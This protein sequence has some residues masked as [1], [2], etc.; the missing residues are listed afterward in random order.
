VPAF[1]SYLFALA[2]PSAGVGAIT[3]YQ[4]SKRKKEKLRNAK[5]QEKAGQVKTAGDYEDNSP[6]AKAIIEHYHKNPAKFKKIYS[7]YARQDGGDEFIN[8][9]KRF[10]DKHG[11]AFDTTGTEYHPRPGNFPRSGYSRPSSYTSRSRPTSSGGGSGAPPPRSGRRNPFDDCEDFFRNSR[12]RAD[13][14]HREWA[15]MRREYAERSARTYA[16]EQAREAEARA[17][18]MANIE[19][20]EKYVRRGTMAGVA[21]LGTYGVLNATVPEKKKRS[22]KSLREA[23]ILGASGGAA[24]LGAS[25]FKKPAWGAAGAL[26][27]LAVG[28]VNAWRREMRSKARKKKD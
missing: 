17:R 10:A 23:L 1:A 9:L 27:G 16:E 26:A 5:K 7:V 13:D 11:I 22:D 21:G 4:A 6:E 2:G 24:G 25:G 15:R 12:Q 19:K 3:G 20:I 8:T 28:G 14:L 18:R